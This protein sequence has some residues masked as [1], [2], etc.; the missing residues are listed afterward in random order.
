ML[1]TTVFF[2]S[3][4]IRASLTI[5]A[6]G[7]LH[8]WVQLGAQTLKDG[9]EKGLCHSPSVKKA[10]AE[11]AKSFHEIDRV[12]AGSLPQVSLNTRGGAAFRNRSIEGLQV[13]NG[14]GLLARDARITIEQIL[15]DF[16]T[17]RLLTES[18]VLRNEFQ[19]LLIEDI[20]EQQA[21]LI[22]ETYLEVFKNRLESKVMEDHLSTLLKILKDAKNLEVEEGKDDSLVLEGR[23]LTAR[24]KLAEI[25]ARIKGLDT[26]F[27]LLTCMDGTA[28]MGLV[29][30]PT[31]I[32]DHVDILESPRVKAAELAIKVSEANIQAS[33]QDRMPKF[34]F[35]GVS[36]IGENV[37]GINGSDKEWGALITMKWNVFDGYRKK[38]II[39]QNLTELDKDVAARE[40]VILSIKDAV[41]SNQEEL[42]GAIKRRSQLQEAKGKIGEALKLYQAKLEAGEKKATL[43]GLA[44]NNREYLAIELESI[45]ALISGYQAAVRGM[46]AA[47]GF[48]E[49]LGIDS[50]ACCAEKAA[51][52]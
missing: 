37:G 25:V 36:G 14:D 4:L 52:D 47:G 41:A 8:P 12:S 42:N 26:R 28:G 19:K 11:A 46:V 13:A 23:I 15:F 51:S 10:L 22:G 24:S 2:K 31:S 40:D 35:E 17:N 39:C 1:S 20:R 16:G 48:L 49:Y 43:L 3:P 27:Q 33:R 30:M 34:Y 21:G 32:C 29:K 18:A 45:N 9:V 38:A 7:T 6:L 44:N 5:I 50:A